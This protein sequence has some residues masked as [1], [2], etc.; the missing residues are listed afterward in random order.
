MSLSISLTTILLNVI[1]F[2]REKNF[3]LW[4][5]K[6]KIFR[7]NW[8]FC[9][10]KERPTFRNCDLESQLKLCLIFTIL[11]NLLFVIFSSWSFDWYFGSD[12]EELYKVINCRL[13]RR[14]DTLQFKQISDYVLSRNIRY[15]VSI[16]AKLKY[17]NT[18]L[19]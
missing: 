13:S 14:R 11:Y 7:F 1:I 10:R 8:L 6:R 18:Q 12:S 19:Q 3:N 5:K 4:L 9:H 2:L 17:R 16:N 15:K